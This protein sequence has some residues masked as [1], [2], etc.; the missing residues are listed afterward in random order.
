MFK[1]LHVK[2]GD[3]VVV[4]AGKD[5]GKRGK[6]SSVLTKRDRIYV[7]G[8]NLQKKHI[9]KNQQHPNGTI[10]EREGHIHVSN[11]M[12]LSNFENRAAKR[13]SKVKALKS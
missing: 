8:V 5:K 10:L 12:L 6:V 2:S 13:V 1:K 4:I 7:E 3:Q 11:V 9:R